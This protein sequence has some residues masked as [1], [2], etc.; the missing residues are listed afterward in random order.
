M[1]KR[2]FDNGHY[3]LLVEAGPNFSSLV[4]NEFPVD[5]IWLYFGAKFLGQSPSYGGSALS[6]IGQGILP[7]YQV[8]INDLE[9][10]DEENILLILQ[11]LRK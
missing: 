7:G 1:E 11:P 9:K 5:E 2:I 8:K 6:Q 4:L 3:D 10:I